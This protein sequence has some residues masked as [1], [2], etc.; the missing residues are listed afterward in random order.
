MKYTANYV[1]QCIECNQDFDPERN[2]IVLS[3]DAI[4]VKLFKKND[5]MYKSVFIFYALPV[6]KMIKSFPVFAMMHK[7]GKMNFEVAEKTSKIIEQINK[8]E[9]VYISIKA[10]DGD[11]GSNMEH[12]KQF[13]EIYKIY[14]KCGFKEVI[15]SI[16]NNIKEKTQTY[17][18]TDMIH[19]GKNRRTQ[20][21]LIGLT[22]NN[23]NINLSPLYDILQN[24]GAINDKSSLSKLQDAFPI[25]IFN[26]AVIEKL[27][28]YKAW[29]LILYILPMACWLE[30]CLNTTLNKPSRLLLLKIAFTM[31]MK[32]Y[33]MQIDKKSKSEF[34]TQ[35][36]LIR[37]LN[38]IAVLYEEFERSEK[39]FCFA[40]YSTMIQEHFHGHIRGLN[41]NN[42][43]VEEILFN[44]AKAG[45][46]YQ[47]KREL[48]IP[49]NV[50][51]RLSVGGIQWDADV[52]KSSAIP[53]AEDIV[54]T[55][56]LICDFF[57]SYSC[58]QKQ[59][60]ER[61]KI[62]E[63]I[64]EWISKVASGTYKLKTTFNA[65]HGRHIL[66][67]QIT[68]S[69]ELKPKMRISQTNDIDESD[70]ER[71][72]FNEDIEAFNKAMNA[73]E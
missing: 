26:F 53:F 71:N 70:E 7:T 12:I 16:E 64:M 4:D 3:I 29:D 69:K 56:E 55:P 17:I 50:K 57:L 44:I 31:Y 51:T 9:N 1:K 67:R 48:D 14:K 33:E 20:L 61:N 10:V 41:T 35:I 40:R 38:T 58:Y 47:Y 2:D 73:D 45:L 37:A 21:I 43:N 60:E 6:N 32:I 54:V 36:S 34:Q 8:L 25:E 15:S 68:N 65:Y 22:L 11:P 46:V 23:K 72:S 18:I 42:D 62:Y 39:S 59:C 13:N 24:S 27:I 66:T 30:S 49:T 28:K 5:Q 52:H 63:S 19:F